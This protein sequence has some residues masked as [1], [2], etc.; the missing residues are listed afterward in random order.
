MPLIKS[1]SIMVAVDNSRQGIQSEFEFLNFIQSVSF[2]VNANRIAQKSVGRQDAD[3]SQFVA[4]EVNLNVTFLQRTDFF[5]ELMLGF[6][7]IT[8]SDTDSIAKDLIAGFSNRNVFI[9]TSDLQFQDLAYQVSNSNFNASMVAMSIGNVFLNSYAFSYKVGSLP[10]V[11][12]SLSGSQMKVANVLSSGGFNLQNWDGTNVLLSSSKMTNF[13]TN[14]N[15]DS[16]QNIVWHMKGL[17]FSNTFSS[18]STPAV[19][20]TDLLSGAISSLD[21]SIDFARSKYYFFEQGTTPAE[22]KILPPVNCQLKISGLTTSFQAGQLSTMF[23]QDQKFSM[24]LGVGTLTSIS[25]AG[26]PAFTSDYTELL[27]DQLFVEKFSYSID[28]NGLMS[29]TLDCRTQITDR[30][31]LKIN[32]LQT[33]DRSIGYLVSSDGSY[34]LSSNNKFLAVRA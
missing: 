7:F 16:G 15:N 18:T 6:H 20:I 27:F 4:P 9:L 19:V 24:T 14:T 33:K 32:P 26:N 12:V 23:T 1:N 29:Y 2:D 22:R 31:G 30:Q 8:D 17:S 25:N 5:N 28:I 21:M 3:V 13:L 11:S 34:L 10:A